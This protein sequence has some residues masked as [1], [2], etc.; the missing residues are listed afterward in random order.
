MT[1]LCKCAAIIFGTLLLAACEKNISV[2]VPD[3]P[4]RLV[5]YSINTSEQDSI[6]VT[7]HRSEAILKYDKKDDLSIQNALVVL[8]DNGQPVDTLV[9][10]LG[11]YRSKTIPE[12]GHLYTLKVSAPG[13]S[14]VAEASALMPAEIPVTIQ[15]LENVRPGNFG[16]SLDELQI[17]FEDP[18]SNMDYYRI[19]ITN[20][21]AGEMPQMNTC[22]D[23]IDPALDDI[24]GESSCN[25]EGIYLRDELFNGTSKTLRIFV[26]HNDIDRTLDLNGN[27]R[28]AVIQF[29]HLGTDYYRYL[30][31]YYYMRQNDGNPFVEPINVNTNV[32]NGYGIF[33][34]ISGRNFEIY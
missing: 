11:I 8:L 10:N 14:G 6:K 24:T 19:L 27:E 21:Y 33:T 5:I 22:M 1:L 28:Y 3:L 29:E 9:Y 34:I 4:S 16:D 31:R 26:S 32:K 7:V 25:N 12:P 18:V 2:K 17:R 13:F 23:I 20:R 30:Q 15:R